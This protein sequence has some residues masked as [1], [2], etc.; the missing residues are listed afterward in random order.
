MTEPTITDEFV[1]PPLS[2][3]QRVRLGAL[4]DEFELR[5]DSGSPVNPEDLCADDPEL[6]A[7][8]RDSLK[9]LRSL[10]SR[11]A[12][13]PALPVPEKIGEFLVV[14]LLG[15]GATGMV[16]RCRQQNPDR[17]VAVKVLKPMLDVE[18]QRRRF[19]REMAVFSAINDAGIAAVYQTGI[20]EWC[21]VHC[22]WIAMELLDGGTICEYVARCQTGRSELLHLFRSVCTTLQ[23]AHRLG[24]LH[25]DIKP[26]NLLMSSDGLPHIVDFGIARLPS[27]YA[28]HQ[29]TETGDGILRGTFAWMA[30][31]LL[32][33]ETPHPGDVRSEIFS[34][35]VVLFQLL[36]GRHPFDADRLTGPQ[37]VARLLA[38]R[39]AS[40]D[41]IAGID[42]KDLRAFVF[43]M[44]AV[45]PQDR[46]QSL[47]SVLTD[48]D[49]L[50]RGEPIRLRHVAICERVVRWGRRNRLAMAAT[51][52]ILLATTVSLVTVIVSSIRVRHHAAELQIAN[53]SLSR[54]T[55]QLEAQTASL[56][57]A[58][59]LQQRS[60]VNGKLQS[61]QRSLGEAP[62]EVHRNLNDAMQ[63]PAES[64]GFAW[65]LLNHQS[66]A[67]YRT[68]PSAG[69]M[70]R[71]MAF[72]PSQ[73]FLAATIAP[74]RLAIHRL[75]SDAMTHS[76][77]RILPASRLTFRK[78]SRSV[79]VVSADHVLLEIGIPDGTVVREFSETAGMTVRYA[80]SPDEQW[81][82]GANKDQHPFVLDLHTGIARPMAE[83]NTG[84]TVGVWF[85]DDSRTVNTVDQSGV[86]RQWSADTLQLART[87]DLKETVPQLDNLVVA[88]YSAKMSEG[89]ILALSQGNGMIH[90]VPDQRGRI[91][92][93]PS[94]RLHGEAA[95]Q[96]SFLPPFH[97]VTV[98]GSVRL[99][100]LF[101]S[102]TPGLVPAS[103]G[104][105]T[106]LAVSPDRCRIAIGGING[107]SLIV[108]L[109]QLP[110]ERQSFGI[111]HDLPDHG[112]GPPKS[113]FFD[114]PTNRLMIG[115]LGG[116]L[117]V[118]DFTTGEP[119]EAFPCSQGPVNSIVRHPL[120]PLIAISM[121]G[122][123]P[124]IMVLKLSE[125]GRL[126]RPTAELL[127]ETPDAVAVLDLDCDIRMIRFSADGKLLVAVTRNGEVVVIDCRTWKVRDR[128]P[129]HSG[130]AF[131]LDLH[132]QLCVS[133]G[134]DGF[135]QLTSLQENQV[136]ARWKAH[137]K[138][139]T[140]VLF[141][142]SG[143]QFYTAAND[144]AI[145]AWTT[146]GQRQHSLIR[147]V[148]PVTCLAL[149]PDGETLASGGQDRQILL[150]DAVTGD[151]Q[152]QIDQHQEAVTDLTFVGQGAGLG[153][154]SASLDGTVRLWS[155]IP[156]AVSSDV[157]SE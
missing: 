2:A 98:S 133:G 91:N 157:T 27:S 48:L 31:E 134:T 21:D 25:R 117:G 116:W 99:L 41:N 15:V 139:I 92:P 70:I 24:I 63:F 127:C 89:G 6:L 93:L 30:P 34:L 103:V 55:R 135:L 74:D 26:S 141:S 129:V 113:L 3:S 23:T 82:A 51:V 109:P 97:L 5:R 22:L 52:T 119:S 154:V 44:L 1:L 110:I 155:S 137:E 114:K 72:D 138:R 88:E 128:R 42:S 124:S 46:Y 9:R 153:L 94:L 4:I 77:V 60:I 108:G 67:E 107:A 35:G 50:I 58:L 79:F 121:S 125:D 18:D 14:E 149:S 66:A 32:L 122:D 16:F 106:S 53:S 86:H 75:E 29:R 76:D 68:L 85:T 105:A 73:Q 115:H 62:Q 145:H 8:L 132:D 95:R 64:R 118:A 54:Q 38:G 65:Q 45:N 59:R 102:R 136:V 144:G 84:E 112:Y 7:P 71:Q 100:H 40:A 140:A 104:F 10:D 146:D 56:G 148:G 96:M 37:L 11:L 151:L 57:S 111:F 131:A 101:E 28:A 36:T 20:V 142:Q 90:L 80:V 47:D 12:A 126:C 17:D 120:K 143:K 87:R 152:F 123:G 61:M 13:T 78:D 130:G 150:W 43:G 147:H 39:P 33:P 19:D 83:S 156:D 69:D 81:V 49:L